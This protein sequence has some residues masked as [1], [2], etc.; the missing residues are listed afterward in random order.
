M[1]DEVAGSCAGAYSVCSSALDRA[2]ST[3]S[4]V[5]FE[6]I[7]HTVHNSHLPAVHSFHRYALILQR[8]V[9]YADAGTILGD[10]PGELREANTS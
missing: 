10:R 9:C 1:G 6:H 8:A 5:Y 2:I 3:A 4:N 7:V